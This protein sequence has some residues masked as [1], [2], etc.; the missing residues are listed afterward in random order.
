MWREWIEMTSSTTSCF[1]VLSP[2]V[3]RE[4]IEILQGV[5]KA[6]KSRSPSVWR[7]WIE[8]EIL[9]PVTSPADVSLR[10]EGVD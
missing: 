6:L 7:E 2:S 10:V 8:I 1:S 5:G 4:W 9:T 3:W